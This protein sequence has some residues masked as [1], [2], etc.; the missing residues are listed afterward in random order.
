MTTF[1]Y[2]THDNPLAKPYGTNIISCHRRLD[3]AQAA[4]LREA[5]AFSQSG[6]SRGG[7]YLQRIIVEFDADGDPVA[8]Y[9]PTPDDV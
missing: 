1:E 4:G 3:T 8:T 7:A 2:R 6:H 5:R 9:P